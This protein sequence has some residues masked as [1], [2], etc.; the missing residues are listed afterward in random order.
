MLV[1]KN[2]YFLKKIIKTQKITNSGFIDIFRISYLY[3]KNPPKR[4]KGD[5]LVAKM[6]VYSSF[7]LAVSK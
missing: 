2:V 7:I 1:N 6:I 5:P 4:I 3:A